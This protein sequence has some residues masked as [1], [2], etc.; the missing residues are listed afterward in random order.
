MSDT[1]VQYPFDPAGTATT[2]RISGEL[3]VL[4]PPNYTDFYFIV[5]NAP[6]FF[7]N[8]LQI[9]HISTGR[10]LVEGQDYVLSHLFHDASLACATEIYGSITIYDKTLAGAVRLTYQTLGGTWTLNEQQI[11]ELLSRVITDPRVTTWE[12]VVELPIR[13][14][15]IDHE[16]D[17]VDMVGA[18]EVVEAIY[19]VEQAIREASDAGLPAHLADYNNPHRTTKDQVNLGNVENYPVAT[20]QEA[21]AGTAPDRYMTAQRTRQAIVAWSATTF[22]VHAADQANPHGVNATQVGL[23]AVQN[24]GLATTQ[25]AQG[26]AVNN[27]YMTPVLVKAAIDF[28]VM[29]T[30]TTHVAD[31]NN[32]HQ[33]NKTQV[34]LGNV[35]NLPLADVNIARAGVSNVHYMTPAL[36]REAITAQ[37][38]DGLTAHLNDKTNPHE[39][40]KSQVGL[41]SV[42]DFGIA[43]PQEAQAGLATNKYMTPALVK[44][45]IES[46]GGSEFN[47]HIIDTNNP[48]Q[49]SKTQVQLGN[50]QNFGLATTQEAA[51]GVSNVKYMTPALVKAAIDALVDLAPVVD[52]LN[53]HIAQRNPHG[54]LASDVGAYSTTQMDTLLGNKLDVSGT[55]ADSNALGGLNL[56]QVIDRASVLR[57]FPKVGLDQIPGT[58]WTKLVSYAPASEQEMLEDQDLVFELVGGEDPS[59]G[60]EPVFRIQVPSAESYSANVQQLDGA[61]S[62]MQF[63]V[64]SEAP[65]GYSLWVQSLPGRAS[66]TMRFMSNPDVD[67]PGDVEDTKPTDF[68][69]GVLRT[70][71]SVGMP[72]LQDNGA[73]GDLRF[74]IDPTGQY[75]PVTPTGPLVEWINI[76][77]LS[78]GEAASSVNNLTANLENDIADWLPRSYYAISPYQTSTAWGVDTVAN[79]V[80]AN[81]TNFRL[82]ALLTKQRYNNYTLEVELASTAPGAA[83]TLGVCVAHTQIRGRDYAIHVLRSPG[84]LPVASENGELPGK[85]EYKLFTVA[86]NALQNDAV[87]LASTSGN[88]L[89]WGDGVTD[90]DRDLT[91]NPFDNTAGS[92]ANA[93]PV[94]LRITR[95]G[96]SIKIETTNHGSTVYVASADI[97]IDLSAPGLEMFS[98]YPSAYGLVNYGQGNSSFKL[99]RRPDSLEPYIVLEKAAGGVDIS[100]LY[101]YNGD[102]WEDDALNRDNQHVRPG[103]LVFSEWNGRQMFWRRDGRIR[104]M[105]IEAYTPSPTS[106]FSDPA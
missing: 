37:S 29:G 14:P 77:D 33:V 74:G 87:V 72:Q 4:S 82:H 75:D 93:G 53:Q 106:V 30:L 71:Q 27:K 11:L 46:L 25:E 7:R 60:V 28:I 70:W 48:H 23:G 88:G 56:S 89:I 67:V 68:D 16:W 86:L 24:F 19:A 104:P 69:M 42:Q 43:T 44:A 40:T 96:S 39:T 58:S 47:A 21:A 38:T 63:S 3:R 10:V 17:L 26:G 91:A 35:Q 78:I 76:V 101:R 22:D 15:V 2:N 85:A 92:W 62:P 66:F 8:G 84:I 94:R 73:A 51:A 79:T 102:E 81:P 45:A 64:I 20:P 9:V 13:F 36:V 95:T 105:Y 32:P 31:L 34:Q 6:P 100:R 41:G 12:Q 80:T 52:L 83:N 1:T 65:Y 50:V 18:S 55:A 61:P 97:T 59:V 5:P 103:R 98:A 99:L 49:V 90:S 54:T 57:R